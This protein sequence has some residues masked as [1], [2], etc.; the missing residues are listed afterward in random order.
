MFKN[1]TTTSLYKKM[2]DTLVG[3]IIL[4]ALRYNPNYKGRATIKDVLI[5]FTVIVILIP[6]ILN[7]FYI[8]YIKSF[9]PLYL[10]L[11]SLALMPLTAVITRRF[12]DSNRSTW[13]WLTFLIPYI[14]TFIFLYFVFAPHD[15]E[16]NI[17]GPNP[18]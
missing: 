18:R 8:F 14:G 4:W 6:I 13:T 3:A 10:I 17:Y 9:F 2:N 1:L 7:I 16:D 11:F 15:R 12:H 5:T